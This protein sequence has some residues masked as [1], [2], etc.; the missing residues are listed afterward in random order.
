MK[1]DDEVACE[2]RYRQEVDTVSNPGQDQDGWKTVDLPVIC[3]VLLLHHCNVNVL[4]WGLLTLLLK[5]YC[6][7]EVLYALQQCNV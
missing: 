3:N 4:Y 7:L 5:C 1:E 6:Y 2:K